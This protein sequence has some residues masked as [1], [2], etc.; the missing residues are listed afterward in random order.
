M[1]L[2]ARHAMRC[3]TADAALAAPTQSSAKS[4]PSTELVV[5]AFAAVYVIWGSTYLGIRLAINSIPPLLMAGFRFLLAGA[6]LYV[7][8]RLRGAIKPTLRQWQSAAV[9]GGLL[10]LFGNGG[11]SWA[12]QTVPSGIAA[13]VVAAVPLWI[14]LVDWL[15]PQGARPKSVVWF[16]LAVGFA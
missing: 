12:Q 8:M 9:I 16:G 5:A 6:I 1:L 3:L 11:V 2:R 7:V 15:R 10:L 13:L 4:Q 14:M